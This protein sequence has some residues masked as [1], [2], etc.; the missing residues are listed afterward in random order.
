MSG[1]PALIPMA[2][3]AFKSWLLPTLLALIPWKKV[4][5]WFS[6]NAAKA[7][8]LLKGSGTSSVSSNAAKS[9][10]FVAALPNA[11][12][13][14]AKKGG[15]VALAIMGFCSRNPKLAGL[16]AI[17]GACFIMGS[18]YTT[19][20]KTLSALLDLLRKALKELAGIG[21]ISEDDARAHEEAL[22]VINKNGFANLTEKEAQELQTVAVLC[23]VTS[24]YLESTNSLTTDRYPALCE[25]R[26]VIDNAANDMKANATSEELTDLETFAVKVVEE[27]TLE[28]AASSSKSGS[29]QSTTSATSSADPTLLAAVT[30]AG[31]SL[32]GQSGDAPS[33]ALPEVQVSAVPSGASSSGASNASEPAVTLASAGSSATPALDEDALSNL[34]PSQMEELSTLVDASQTMSEQDLLMEESGSTSRLLDTAKELCVKWGLPIALA[35]SIAALVIAAVRARRRGSSGDNTESWLTKVST[36]WSNVTGSTDPSLGTS[37]GDDVTGVAL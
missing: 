22:E 31:G 21:A 13:T 17:L 10:G 35:S 4:S 27:V 28:Q 6:K 2:W 7:K 25:L 33:Q 37:L 32:A 15:K 3:S 34:T 1:S 16:T 36:W 5:T 30:A 8:L 14:I 9:T 23:Y 19:D 11:L 24:S 29:R 26:E 18:S 20:T 12:R